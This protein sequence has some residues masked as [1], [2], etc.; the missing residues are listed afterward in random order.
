MPLY[1]AYGINM[2]RQAMGA[3]APSSRPL[4]VARLARHRFV[5]TVDGYASVVRDPRRDVHGLLWDLAL[6]DV[7][8]LDRFEALGRLYS[9]VSQGVITAD[10]AKRALVYIGRGAPGGLAKPGY[11]AAVAHAARL[12]GLPA[13]AIAEIE[14]WDR[15]EAV[16]ATAGVSAVAKRWQWGD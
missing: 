12:A 14:A 2:D 9:K 13:Q 3:R 4:G 6:A 8:A 11:V 5:I 10:G 7:P 16:S 1:F 15:R